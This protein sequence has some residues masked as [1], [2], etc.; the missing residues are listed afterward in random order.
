METFMDPNILAI[1]IIVLF[2]VAAVIG[3]DAHSKLFE[4]F[5]VRLI[6]LL[7]TILFVSY[8][9]PSGLLF[10]I[11]LIYIFTNAKCCNSSNIT[12]TDKENISE[13]GDD[14]PA[15]FTKFK[16]MLGMNKKNNL[17]Q[18][19][20]EENSALEDSAL[21]DSAEENSALEDSAVEIENNKAQP[22]PLCAGESYMA[23]AFAT[24]A[25]LEEAQNNW[26]SNIPDLKTFYD[27]QGP[28]GYTR[29]FVASTPTMPILSNIS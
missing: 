12:A 19:I 4:F 25:Q 22:Q 16:S 29:E 27:T 1:R 15:P 9:I 14:P 17:K 7:F 2:L 20:E 11:G 3:I 13:K 8:D 5:I 23:G 6:L 18:N 21:E 26:V 24:A 28:Q 10:A